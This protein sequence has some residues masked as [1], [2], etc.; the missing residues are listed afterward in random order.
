M[1]RLHLF[2][3]TDR[4]KLVKKE[5]NDSKFG[6]HVQLITHSSNIYDQLKTLDVDFVLFGIPEDIGVFANHGVS[7]A[8]S[9]WDAVVKVLLNIQNNRFTNPKR[10]AIIGHLDF[11]KEQRQ[12]VKYDQ[13]KFSDIKKARKIVEEID[14]EVTYLVHQITKAGK[15]PIV[16]GGGHNNAYGCIKGTSLTLNTPI[17]VINLDAH[18]D[19]RAE[20]GRH[21]G[22]AFSYAYA[23]G[24]LKKY[25]IF[26]VHEN[27]MLQHIYETLNKLK[28]HITY[29]TFEDIVIRKKLKFRA[30]CE[31]ANNFVG[32]KPFGIEIDCDAIGNMASSAMT[33]SGF[34][35]MKTREFLNYFATNSN[36]K[37]L[38]ISEA[39]PILAPKKRAQLC[40]K[41][42]VDLITDF[43]KA[44]SND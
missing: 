26:G 9:T 29:N 20:E 1:N 24:F 18:T 38:H 27:Y 7:G 34:T 39:A 13:N 36:A 21:S 43:M 16:I 6:N 42:I 17:N 35:P 37:Y 11:S 3:E 19:F 44:S 30:E 15:K 4:K 25:F 14:K 8:Y 40:A 12:I 31:R 2:T 10:L 5:S 33:L 28:K 41:L 32:D 23:E 22:N